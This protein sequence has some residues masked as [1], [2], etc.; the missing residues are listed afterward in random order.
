MPDFITAKAAKTVWHTDLGLYLA[1]PQ[2]IFLAHATQHPFEMKKRLSTVAVHLNLG[3]YAAILL[4]FYKL[5][6]DV[7]RI[8]GS[9]GT[10]QTLPLT[11]QSPIIA[12]THTRQLIGASNESLN[13]KAFYG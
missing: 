5:F 11:R 2:Y 3:F 10:R 6:W 4:S 9:V 1:A 8:F 13:M 12:N 7:K